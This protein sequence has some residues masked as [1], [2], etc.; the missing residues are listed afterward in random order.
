[1]PVKKVSTWDNMLEGLNKAKLTIAT[2][3]FIIT[4]LVG[5]YELFNKY[6]VTVAYADVLVEKAVSSVRKEVVELKK[7]TKANKEILV[8]M[9]MIRIENKMANDQNLTPT[10][11]RV[12]E[13][14]KK[15]YS[16]F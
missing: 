16:E 12:Y 8:E 13:K 3:A 14:L 2:I 4:S 5:G 9:R 15:E 1:M 6:I 11:Q 7:Q 10:E